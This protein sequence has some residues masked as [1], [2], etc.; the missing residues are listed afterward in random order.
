MPAIIEQ[1]RGRQILK[2]TPR[3]NKGYYLRIGKVKAELIIEHLKE[4]QQ[5]IRI[6][7]NEPNEEI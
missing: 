2:I 6:C 3:N 7:R 1:F 5:F 4:I